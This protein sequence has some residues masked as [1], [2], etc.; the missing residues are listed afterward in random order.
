MK[1]ANAIK[2]NNIKTV[3]K[4][5][6]IKNGYPNPLINKVFKT[7]LNRLKYIKGP[8]K[9]PVLL[10][11]PYIGVKSNQIERNIKIMTEK[12]YRSSSQE[13]FLHQLLF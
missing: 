4:D 13:L 1:K 9:F 5:M 10:I 8:E 2:L 6:L 11:L 3:I 12:V 7:D